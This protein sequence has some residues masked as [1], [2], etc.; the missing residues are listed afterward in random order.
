MAP[1]IASKAVLLDQLVTSAGTASGRRPIHSSLQLPRSRSCSRSREPSHDGSSEH[2]RAGRRRGSGLCCALG[3]SPGGVA[4]AAGAARAWCCRH[5]AR[6]GVGSE[7]G[8]VAGAEALEVRSALRC[9]VRLRVELVTVRT[10]P[11]E[12][13]AARSGC[14]LLTL[15]NVKVTIALRAAESP[16]GCGQQLSELAVPWS[17]RWAGE[18]R[19]AGHAGHAGH[20]GRSRRT[21]QRRPG[22][23][24]RGTRPRREW[25]RTQQYRRRYRW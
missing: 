19:G 10:A 16:V 18:D 4:S 8:A 21:T 2:A 9:R 3:P 23:A 5:A 25:P 13:N 6:V 12:Q 17:A 15:A 22:R 1:S 14:A 11:G 24:A 20:A 7:R